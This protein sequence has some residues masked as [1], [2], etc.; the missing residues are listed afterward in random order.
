MIDHATGVSLVKAG[1]ARQMIWRDQTEN[2]RAHP[3]ANYAAAAAAAVAVGVDAAAAAAEHGQSLLLPAL[4]IALA[5]PAACSQALSSPWGEGAVW[6]CFAPG[7]SEQ[8]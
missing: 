4:V 8:Q 7:V 3:C 5:G 1:L 2:V 6:V